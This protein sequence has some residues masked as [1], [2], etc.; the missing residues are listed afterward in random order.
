MPRH[1]LNRC[2]Y[3][4][5]PIRF[6]LFYVWRTALSRGSGAHRPRQE[7]PHSMCL[8]MANGVSGV[9][10]ERAGSSGEAQ[11]DRNFSSE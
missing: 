6:P 4:G 1:A 5:G 9:S 7:R 3:A 10:P 11:P 2:D 8:P